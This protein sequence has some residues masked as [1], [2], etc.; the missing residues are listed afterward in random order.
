MQTMTSAYLAKLTK[1]PDGRYLVEFPDLPDALTDR[2]TKQEALEEAADCLTA[3]L[4]GR[5]VDQAD[6]PAPSPIRRGLFR[7]VPDPTVALKAE[8]YS[9]ARRKSVTAADLARALRI[10]HRQARRLLDPLHASKLPRLRAALA[11]VGR[12]IAITTHE[13]GHDTGHNTAA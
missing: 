6:I 3:T 4:T 11:V 5:I 10:D 9:A 8:L 7:I 1:G 2:A 13:T 12:A